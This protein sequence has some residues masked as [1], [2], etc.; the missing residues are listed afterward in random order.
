MSKEVSRFGVESEVMGTLRFLLALS[1]I[2]A[3]STPL[4][5]LSMVGGVTAVQTFYMISGFYMQLVLEKKYTGKGSYWRFFSNRMLRIFPTYWFITALT[6]LFLLFT[7]ALTMWS[8][9]GTFPSLFLALVN[10][11]IVG[12]DLVMFLKF[13]PDLQSLRPTKNFWITHPPV[14]EWLLVPQAWTISLE[15][16]FYMLAPWLV[17]LRTK[18][19]F[20][21]AAASLAFRFALYA[22]GLS[23]DPWTYRFFPLELF[24]FAIGILT[25]RYA[26]VILPRIR[27]HRTWILWLLLSALVVLYQ[28]IPSQL[29]KQI[30]LYAI[31]ICALP[32]LFSF[33][34]THHWD[35]FVGELSYP[36]YISHY[37]VLQLLDWKF[38][39]ESWYS[40][41]S[42]LLCVVLTVIF[43]VCLMYGISM[44]IDRYRQQRV[45]A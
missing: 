11:T 7:G 5:G 30:I 15:L 44:P 10:V 39:G 13:T 12:Q 18:T 29:P 20:L 45:K 37:L 27:T 40:A 22:K 32:F 26:R 43:S 31:T 2:I 4:F 33:T 8:E 28:F 24:F 3:H 23:F 42:G 1:V 16:L 21:I 17:R 38:K 41:Q 25:F 14:H 34:N 6:V 36:M 35:H 19:L 9:I